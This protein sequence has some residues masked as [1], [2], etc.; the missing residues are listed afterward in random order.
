MPLTSENE[1]THARKSSAV[2]AEN[3]TGIVPVKPLE[4]SNLHSKQPL[5]Q[6]N[7]GIFPSRLLEL[8]VL[9]SNQTHLVVDEKGPVFP[10]GN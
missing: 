3:D 4:E 9:Q 6:G 8:R 2:S 5:E 10:H 1:E 7:S